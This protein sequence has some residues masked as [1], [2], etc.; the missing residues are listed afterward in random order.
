MPGFALIVVAQGHF[1][2][3][4]AGVVLVAAVM[5]AVGAD[6]V[7][8]L[9]AAVAVLQR[10]AAVVVGATLERQAA[11]RF[12]AGGGADHIDHAVEG[13][14]AMY[15]GAR[16]TQYLNAAG[17]LAVDVKQFINVTEAPPAQWDTVFGEEE[18]A[19]TAG[20]GQ[21][22]GADGSEVLLTIAAANPYTGDP[23]QQLTNM[24]V[25]DGI[26]VGF[27]HHTERQA[28]VRQ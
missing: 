13:V 25:A 16:S 18:S 23:V 26:D 27:I 28:L 14:G 12:V 8:V 4:K 17:L 7:A 5:A 10:D 21:H 1:L 11:L 15:G 19:T 9:V 24:N 22:R 6:S 2:L 20:A 3:V